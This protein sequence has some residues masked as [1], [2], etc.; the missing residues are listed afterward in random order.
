MKRGYGVPGYLFTFLLLFTLCSALLPGAAAGAEAVGRVASVEGEADVL[1]G[2]ALPAVPLKAGDSV[3]VGDVVRTKSDARVEIVFE[4]GTVL[5]VAPR[6]RIDI[7]EYEPGS[8]GTIRLPRGKI[9][10][11]VNKDLAKKAGLKEPNRFEVHTP[12]AVAGVRGTDFFVY[13]SRNVTGVLVREGT[14]Y[15]FNPE[16]PKVVV[17]VP[18]GTITTVSP[19]SAPQPPRPATEAEMKGL[20]KEVSTKEK[21]KEKTEEK[22]KEEEPKEEKKGSGTAEKP[23]EQAKTEEKPKEETSRS[24]DAPSTSSISTSSSGATTAD[25]NVDQ[26]G[27]QTSGQPSDQPQPS[28]TSSDP[29]GFVPPTAASAPPTETQSL[30]GPSPVESP[31]TKVEEPPLTDIIKDTQAPT[32]TIEEKPQSVMK[33]PEAKFSFSADEPAA[34]EYRLDGGAWQQV[35]GGSSL[36]LS[37]LAIGNHTLEVRAVDKTGNISTEPAS[38]TWSVYQFVADMNTSLYYR[39]SLL[40]ANDDGSLSALLYEDTG[41]ENR[42]SISGSYSTGSSYNHYWLQDLYPQA[43]S[44]VK[45]L[46]YTGMT[47]YGYMGGIERSSSGLDGSLYVL[48]IDASGKAGLAAGSFGGQPGGGS[49]LAGAVASTDLSTTTLNPAEMPT[50]WFSDPAYLTTVSGPGVIGSSSASTEDDSF[51]LFID[52]SHPSTPTLSGHMFNKADDALQFSFLTAAPSFGIWE[53]ETY[54]NYNPVNAKNTWFMGTGAY[55]PCSQADCAAGE[56]SNVALVNTRSNAWRDSS[57]N[58]WGDGLIEGYS[59]GVWGDVEYGMTRILAGALTGSYNDTLDIP[60][61][62]AV[63]I[64]GWVETGKFLSL[65]SDPAMNASLASLG[66]PTV[67]AGSLGTL[68]GGGA[69]PGGS[70]SISISSSLMFS[71]GDGQ[72][73]SIW[74]SGGVTGSY[75]G[76]P[77]ADGSIGLANSSDPGLATLFGEFSLLQWEGGTWLADIEILGGLADGTQGTFIGVAAGSYADGDFSGTAAGLVSSVTALSKLDMAAYLGTAAD[78]HLYGFMG[79]VYQWDSTKD[80]PS[81]M[82]IVGVSTGL[83]SA[84]VHTWYQTIE[85]YQYGSGAKTTTDGGAYYG[86][87][88]G[89]QL[90]AGQDGSGSLDGILYALYVDPSG[91]AGIMKGTEPTFDYDGGSLDASGRWSMSLNTFG[92]VLNESSGVSPFAMPVVTASDSMTLVA[93]S[94]SGGES[95]TAGPIEVQRASFSGENWGVWQTAASGTYTGTAGDSWS[96][97]FVDGDATSRMVDIQMQ[98]SQWSGDIIKGQVAGFWS[99][100]SDGGGMTGIITGETLGTFDPNSFTWQSVSVGAW[101]ETGKFLGMACPGGV[102]TTSGT[103]LTDGQKGLQQLNI[104]FVEVARDSLHGQWDQGGNSFSVDINNAVF[105]SLS[106]GQTPSVWA[107]GEVTGSYAGNPAGA[108]ISMN[109]DYSSAQFALQQWDPAQ[110][111]WIGVVGNG[112]ADFASCGSA[113]SYQGT[114]RFA[115]GAA[116]SIIPGSAESGSITGTAAGRAIR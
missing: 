104:P 28:G 53:M 94:F 66:F 32:V 60:T 29:T 101:M 21:P 106:G 51:G 78:G 82:E 35:T 50:E 59:Y 61:F 55:W 83:N 6:S 68:T 77:S 34:Y 76:T 107:S 109:G 9:Q 22:S 17:N 42:F 25:Q 1:R 96:A 37:A 27:G 49:V 72:A 105:F 88:A 18:A 57:A 43:N 56:V 65:L 108:R 80:T 62:S 73:P 36:T 58:G 100:L 93:G 99:S 20:E 85:P 97:T 90:S 54:G 24:A 81:T 39:G 79:G 86:Y 14:V 3:S 13:H 23:K 70:L 87:L 8:R 64:G 48:Y 95:I 2:G 15:T 26:T 4:D 11:V 110:G 92:T 45:N 30:M 46:T 52:N 75:T 84:N 19:K 113:C 111:A 44:F 71:Y 63:T 103:D 102:C 114:V 67:Q 12:N 74:A 115:G 116:G 5:R 38:F 7:S 91:K 31:V 10:A 40:R 33:E 69:L 112:S 89:V 98:G 16:V 41:A 47:F